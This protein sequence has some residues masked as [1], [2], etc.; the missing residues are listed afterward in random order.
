MAKAVVLLRRFDTFFHMRLKIAIAPG[1]DG[2]LGKLGAEA[3][4]KRVD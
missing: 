3:L 2:L 4:S 1:M